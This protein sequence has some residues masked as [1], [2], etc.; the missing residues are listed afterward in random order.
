[1]RSLRTWLPIAVVVAVLAIGWFIANEPLSDS[2]APAAPESTATASRSTTPAAA[3][4]SAAPPTEVQDEAGYD[5]Q[6]DESR[7]GH[8]IERHVGRTEDQLIQRLE[9]EDISAASTYP[10]LETAEAVVAEALAANQAEVEEWAE[11]SGSRANLALRYDAGRVIGV[12]LRRGSSAPRDATSAVV[13]LRWADNDWYV[14]TSYP[15]D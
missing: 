6:T 9:E 10:D 15:D 5:L 13:V 3:S 14:L 2:S 8:T 4:T 1:M 11:G 7:G 12:T